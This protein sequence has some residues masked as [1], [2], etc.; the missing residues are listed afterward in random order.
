MSAPEPKIQCLYDKL[1]PVSGLKAHPKNRNRH[2]DDQIERLSKI[3]VANPN[4][5][6]DN[7]NHGNSHYRKEASS[8]QLGVRHRR[9]GLQL[10]NRHAEETVEN[11]ARLLTDGGQQNVF[12]GSSPDS[13]HARSESGPKATDQSQER[14]QRRQ[15]RREPRVV[16]SA[17]KRPTRKGCAWNQVRRIWVTKLECQGHRKSSNNFGE[18]ILTRLLNYLDKR[19]NGF[20]NAYDQE[21]SA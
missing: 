5:P 6:L 2:P 15:S 10:K 19:S 3:L 21:A 7:A 9:N 13:G 16:H 12:S 18:S 1:E 17:R 14:N 11:A 8:I 20:L 4:V